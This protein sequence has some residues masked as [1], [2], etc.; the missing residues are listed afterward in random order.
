MVGE[1]RNSKNEKL[2]YRGKGDLGG[3]VVNYKSIGVNMEL[4]VHSAES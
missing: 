3:D 4:K 1:P 2:F